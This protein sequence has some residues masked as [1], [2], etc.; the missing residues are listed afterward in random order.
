MRTATPSAPMR[1]GKRSR[2]F[3]TVA[4]PRALAVSLPSWSS[5]R[6]CLQN[7]SDEWP[8]GSRGSWP[9]MHACSRCL[10]SAVAVQSCASS[11][12]HGWGG[13]SAPGGCSR[14]PTPCAHMFAALMSTV[15]EVRSIG[16]PIPVLQSSIRLNTVARGQLRM[17]TT[18]SSARPSG[19]LG[20]RRGLANG[21][22]AMVPLRW[23]G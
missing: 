6:W 5:S 10:Q 9:C 8:V 15:L 4:S 1:C 22:R 3:V 19:P 12:R 16:W 7:G 2:F 11:S 20:T 13:R 14:G 17:S 18:V 21:G 23:C